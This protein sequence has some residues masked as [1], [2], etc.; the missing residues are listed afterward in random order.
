[1]QQNKRDA[2]KLLRTLFVFLPLYLCGIGY[3]IILLAAANGCEINAADSHPCYFGGVDFGELLYPLS[4]I[5][6][7]FA[8]A[9]MWI[10]IALLILEILKWIKRHL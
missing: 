6:F 9:L 3:C 8:F 7:W 5:G 2:S 10:P 1:M 4:M